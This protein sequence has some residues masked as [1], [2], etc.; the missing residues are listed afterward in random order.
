MPPAT[1]LSTSDR[2]FGPRVDPACRAFDFTLLFEDIF[3]ACLPTAVF[4]SLLP[5]HITLLAKSPA[6]CSV[7][8]KLLLGK[9]A[10]LASVLTAQVILLV[11]RAQNTAV[12]TSASLT[13]D[14][15]AIVGTASVAWLSYIDHQRS[16]RP[17]TL[18]GLFLSVLVILDTA[19]VRTLWLTGSASGEA[20]AM[21]V[22]LALTVVALLLESTEKRSSVI[23]E[24]KRFGA[25]EEYSG[26]WTRTAFAWLVT[27]FRVGY[28][29]VIIQDDLPI[30]DT[31][32]Q[33]NVLY[34]NLVSTWAQRKQPLSQDIVPD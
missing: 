22:T 11:L 8:S 31:R 10:T 33:S 9:L 5:F 15:L 28:S 19:R 18:L 32:L 12:Q 30:L 1:C 25:P 3:F 20:A 24:E 6:V 21:A 34:D 4:F 29:K 17:S 7:T 26:F 14:A 13:A 23:V 27:T 16:L 2:V